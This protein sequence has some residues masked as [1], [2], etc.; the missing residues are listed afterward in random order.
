MPFCRRYFDTNEHD[1]ARQRSQKKKNNA[2]LQ[3]PD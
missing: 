3:Q 1:E 2:A